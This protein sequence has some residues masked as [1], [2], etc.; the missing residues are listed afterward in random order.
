M[1]AD[2]E[3]DFDDVLAVLRGA[4]PAAPPADLARNTT[5]FAAANRA[6]RAPWGAF[7]EHADDLF[8]YLRV[9]LSGDSSLAEELLVEAFARAGAKT[10]PTWLDLVHAARNA[11][12]EAAAK[13]GLP[14]D[15]SLSLGDRALLLER[16][17]GFSLQ[18]LARAWSQMPARLTGR[19]VDCGSR[20]LAELEQR[21]AER[22]APC[23]AWR[24]RLIQAPLDLMEAVE[25]EPYARHLEICPACTGWTQLL[26][27][28]VT[29]TPETLPAP[30]KTKQALKER[31]EPASAPSP[32][33]LGITV[34]VSCCY[35]HDRLRRREAAFCATCLAPHHPDCFQEH[36]RCATPGC[37]GLEVVYPTDRPQ[38]K[39]G[40]LLPGG[41]LAAL[42]GVAAFSAIAYAP[43]E[44]S[45]DPGIQTP[46]QTPV[47]PNQGGH[48][49]L[50]L[51]EDPTRLEIQ[52]GEYSVQDLVDLWA[53]AAG[54]NVTADPQN[55]ALKV[56]LPAPRVLDRVQLRAL[57]A[58]V[59]VV[60]VVGEGNTA[61]AIQRRHLSSK[62]SNP[63]LVEGDTPVDPDAY[64]SRVVR[65]QHGGGNTIFASV[66]GLLTRD[67]NRIGNILYSQGPET[68]TIVDLAR[69]VRYYEE[70]VAQFDVPGVAVQI[71]RAKARVE[72]FH[73][74]SSAWT[75]LRDPDSQAV[76]AGLRNAGEGTLLESVD[77]D[78]D[79]PSQG[80]QTTRVFTRTLQG[81][82]SVH[83]EAQRT[84][85]TSVALLLQT[86]SGG[87]RIGALRCSIPLQDEVSVQAT[88]LSNGEFVVMAVSPN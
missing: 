27:D 38:K 80:D 55:E 21:H 45:E 56:V 61:R 48:A 4:Q 76:L 9:L 33:E 49:L 26:E 60:L 81:G 68:L 17:L 59:D 52:Q 35:C 39:P 40:W 8:A 30:E 29:L 16:R 47:A 78:F 42:I 7:D 5:A 44:R 14:Q 23:T 28:S 36:G 15:G 19:L 50:T 6:P 53:K 87:D 64:V 34:A 43:V 77:V 73:L 10:E 70:M 65:I 84:S 22:D 79:L 82:A 67:V 72:V 25:A 3:R 2:I 13:G 18:Q 63:V 57:L 71:S 58:S 75:A 20:L 51:I 31:L 41:L 12:L 32:Q 62:V 74:P 11:A 37:R 46:V 86:S 54:K 24:A 1:T 66:R 83:L 85:N 69:N 88:L